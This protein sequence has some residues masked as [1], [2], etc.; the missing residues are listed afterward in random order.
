MP[1]RRALIIVNANARR[2]HQVEWRDAVRQVLERRFETAIVVPTSA[3]EPARLARE[4]SNDGAD[5]VIAAGGDGTVNAVA[6][7]L[8]GGASPLGIL[9]LGTA[10]D[11]AR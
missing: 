3:D 6:R 7:G 4:A 10:N 11:L 5:V 1:R 9:P 2:A 8:V